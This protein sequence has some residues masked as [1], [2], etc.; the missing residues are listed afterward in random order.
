MTG[1]FAGTKEVPL[2]LPSVNP[3]P[4]LLERMLSLRLRCLRMLR[5]HCPHTLSIQSQPHK[6]TNALPHHLCILPFPESRTS[7]IPCLLGLPQIYAQGIHVGLPLTLQP[8]LWKCRNPSMISLFS[9]CCG[10]VIFPLSSEDRL[11]RGLDE[12]RAKEEK[13]RNAP[14]SANTQ[15]SQLLKCH[16]IL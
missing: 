16:S 3:G 2:H 7:F 8:G 1:P 5:L 11:P 6:P 10:W 9:L 15:A 4:N 14:L 12:R 13:E